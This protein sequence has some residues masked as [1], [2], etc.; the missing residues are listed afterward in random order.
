M[1]KW[2]PILAVIANDPGSD[3][4]RFL[5][6]GFNGHLSKPDRQSRLLA[7]LTKHL[8]LRGPADSGGAGSG[9]SSR[10]PAPAAGSIDSVLDVDAL[11]RLRDLDPNGENRLMERVVSAFESSV[12]RLMPQ[13]QEALV[14]DQ[15]SGIR[16]VA[17]TLKSSSA[18]IGATKLSKICA[19][20]ESKARLQQT[21]GLAEQAVAL[22]SEVE[23]VR[24]A[25][26]H[27]LK[28]NP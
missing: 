11:N 2:V 20:V 16:H 14:G 27:M 23:T 9:A 4:A 21:E 7:M 10:C 1:C 24:A 12:A 28:S 19:E 8:Q 3:E 18:S 25:L 26:Q 15:L 22:Q 17:H 13:L 6:V 5:G